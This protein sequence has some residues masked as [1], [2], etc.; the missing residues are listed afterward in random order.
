VLF[1]PFDLAGNGPAIPSTGSPSPHQVQYG[2]FALILPI[3]GVALR[4]F[5]GGFTAENRIRDECHS[6]VTWLREALITRDV[7]NALALIAV[8][9]HAKAKWPP[10]TGIR[11]AISRDDPGNP[12]SEAV[13][14]IGYWAAEFSEPIESLEHHF[15][16]ISQATSTHMD[17][18]RFARYNAVSSGVFLAP[19]LYIGVLLLFPWLPRPPAAVLPA[20]VLL[21]L[22]VGW[23]ASCWWFANHRRNAL[24]RLE[25]ATPPLQEGS[26]Q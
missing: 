15:D 13:R 5:V 4:N 16:S 10:T 22:A 9:V 3:A 2:W 26:T 1:L 6:R 20:A 24:S 14:V 11:A 23:S 21:G 25:R 18:V 19:W 12:E 8:R 17:L 7:R